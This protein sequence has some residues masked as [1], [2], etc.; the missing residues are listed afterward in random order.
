MQAKIFLMLGLLLGSSIASASAGNLPGRLGAPGDAD[1]FV[2]LVYHHVSE[3]TPPSTS[4]TPE[5]F[6]E[7][8]QFIHDN[9]Y[10]VWHVARAMRLLHAGAELPDRVVA[11]TFDDAYES[12]YE[13][14]F[15]MLHN[16]RMPFA[17]MVST[18][19]IDAGLE[20]YMSWE[21]LRTLARRGVV[22]GNHGASHSHLPR[23]AP[24]QSD[25]QWTAAAM[26]D[27]R[28]A[29]SSIRANLP[30]AANLFAWPY[31]EDA[32][33]LYDEVLETV[34]FGL[35]QRSGAVDRNTPL[36][37]LPRFPMATGQDSLERLE[38]AL[39]ARAMP[40]KAAETVPPRKR[41]AVTDPERLELMLGESEDFDSAAVSCF[42]SSGDSLPVTQ[43]SD[44]DGVLVVDVSGIGR[45]GRNKVN[46][47]SPAS[48]GSGDH[49]WFSF[50]WLQPGPDGEWP[51][52]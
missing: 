10:R 22:I 11:I 38:M 50:Q 12:V 34:E 2:I 26:D 13:T 6:A 25:E 41:A 15:P 4:I 44:R 37:A 28:R 7:H 14:A 1:H 27:L 21:Q 20:P 43:D 49:Y 30:N 46:C 48:D 5:R 29:Q 52:E 16:K 39:R 3:D 9:D 17:V 42:R 18:D 35:A 40:V 36:A 51:D 32:P 31:G 47:T 23:L 24:E 45:A 19:A 33:E 8:L